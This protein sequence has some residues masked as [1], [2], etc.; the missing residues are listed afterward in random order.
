MLLMLVIIV[1]L[2]FHFA[3]L[4]MLMFAY[5]CDVDAYV[6]LVAALMI[7]YT[8]I[9]SH[10]FFFRYFA[11]PINACSL[12]IAIV[13][14]LMAFCIFFSVGAFGSKLVITCLL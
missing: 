11:V 14:M 10:L 8:N 2:M 7:F 1:T 12:R 5:S 9:F 3:I 4:A 6:M 13:V